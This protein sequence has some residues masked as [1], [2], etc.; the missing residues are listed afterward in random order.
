[1]ESH[2]VLFVEKKQPD[3]AR[4]SELLAACACQSQWA[5]QGP[6]YHALRALCAKHVCL[7][8]T[9][10]VV[11]M[12]NGGMALEALAALQSC[13]AG[14]PLKWVASAYT[15]QNL[16]RGRFNDVIFLDCD[17]RGLL[18]LDA[19]EALDPV[20]YDGIIIT[21][22]FGLYS[23]FSKYTAFAHRA[24]KRLL[25]DN[26]SGFHTRL[27]DVPWQA[28]SLHHTKPY[29]LGE[30]G[31]A[32][33][34]KSQ[35]SR[36]VDL[37]SYGLDF[38]DSAYWVGNC[39][40]SDVA[41][42]FLIDRIESVETWGPPSLQQRDR[43][44]KLASALGLRPLHVPAQNIP[45]TSIPFLVPH[46]LPYTQLARTRHMTFEKYYVP[47][48]PK[49]NVTHLYD[50]IVNIPCHKDVAM[51]EDDAI[52]SDIRSVLRSESIESHSR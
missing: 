31:L 36:L 25:L 35:T 13:R 3:M 24:G 8:E 2:K 5:N 41:C 48:S 14:R 38:A 28:I 7:P 32:I 40:I 17:D 26:A 42:A 27:P 50:R 37:I 1:M 9:W 10:D 45:M 39:K 49:P 21:N 18:D 30:G 23:D 20:C 33:L 34:P 6:L 51:L 4:V 12:A 43:V 52:C 46:E 29:G 47:A 19:L 16:G 15:F 22:P 44:V 11:P